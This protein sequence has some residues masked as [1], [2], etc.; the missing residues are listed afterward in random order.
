MSRFLPTAHGFA[1]DTLSL[2]IGAELDKL[3]CMVNDQLTWELVD[4]VA[5]DLGAKDEA[6]RK[7]R[8]RG[9]PADWR[10]KIAQQLE[11]GGRAFTASDFDAFDALGRAA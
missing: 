4:A 2:T 5:A 9:I 8:D 10:I 3:S 11:I 7:W 6:R 1:R